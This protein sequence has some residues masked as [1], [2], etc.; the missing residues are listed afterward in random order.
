M[1][2][3]TLVILLLLFLAIVTAAGAVARASARQPMSIEERAQLM[4]RIASFDRAL[5]DKVYRFDL[6]KARNHYW[7]ACADPDCDCDNQ[8][9]ARY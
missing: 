1:T 2:L 7:I 9:V 6:D 3:M 4:G 8:I 5:Y